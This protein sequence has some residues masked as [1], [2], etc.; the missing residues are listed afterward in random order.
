MPVGPPS[1]GGNRLK[2]WTE[3]LTQNRVKTVAEVGVYRGQFAERLLRNCPDIATYYLID[4]W[5]H[6]DDW[7]KP[8]NEAD[9]TFEEHYAE[10]LRRTSEWESKR[11]VLRGRTSDVIDS[12]PDGSLDFVYIDGDHT[13]RGITIDLM[14]VWPKVR[15]GGFIGGDDFCP[16]VWQH[17][18]SF[19]PTFVF[20]YAVYFAQA[21]DAPITALP[22]R[23][24]LVERST[25]F[26]FVDAAGVYG[27]LTVKA[28][29]VPPT[30]RTRTRPSL[31]RRVA[32]RVLK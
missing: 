4:P 9:E 28:A 18:E 5:R 1:T 13:L 19:E 31:V 27:D 7:N 22:H 3:F 15:Q 10:A 29:L 24:F 17:A 25:G 20:P 2:L 30:P 14:R 12:I 32:H 21:I 23:Q 11:I 6:L 16:S 26:A 8:A